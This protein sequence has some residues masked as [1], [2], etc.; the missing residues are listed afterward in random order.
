MAEIKIGR[1]RM[2][3]KGTWNSTTTYVAQDAVYYDGETFVAKQDVPVGT[4]TTNATYWQKVAQKGTNGQDGATGA[5]GATGPQGP[6]G[7]QG[8]QGETGPQ[9]ATGPQGPQGDIGDTGPVG[10]QGPIGNTGPT[11]ATGP[12][13]PAGPTGPKGDTGNTGAT[14]AIGPQGPQGST[15]PTGA[16][17]PSGPA[18]AHN[19]SSY[20]LRFQNPNGTWG[21]Y[22]NLRGA[23]GATGA[24]G[25]QGAT[26]AQGPQG[27]TGATGATGP[28][29]AVG[30]SG[31]APSH[32]WSGYSLRFM[33]P[34]GTWGAYT[35]LRGA[36]GAQGPQGVQGEQGPQGNTG[37]TGA[38]GPQGIQGP[39]GDQGPIGPQGP[40][41][42]QG[43]TGPKGDT[44]NTGAQGSTGPQGATGPTPAH[45]WSGTSLRFYNGTAWGSYVNLK[46]DTGAQGPQGP[47]GVG[48][49]GNVEMTGTLD[50]NNYDIYGV[51]QIFHHG[52]TNTYMQFHAS[53]QWRVV[54]GGAERLEV[55]NTQITSAEPIYAPSFHG[56][57]S[58]L[59][60]ISTDRAE[61][62]FEGGALHSGYA[63]TSFQFGVTGS[64]YD[65]YEILIRNRHNTPAYLYWRPLVGTTAYNLTA[66][67]GASSGGYMSLH[68][69]TSSCSVTRLFVS[70]N[71][72]SA[73]TLSYYVIGFSTGMST[74]T[75][76]GGIG[77]GTASNIRM[78]GIQILSSSTARPL[79]KVYGV[80]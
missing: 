74:S 54:T 79:L 17:G 4:A 20:S 68:S 22:T 30:P 11:G 47:Q 65:W 35:N 38:T 69:N 19:W 50:M 6:Q 9:G 21:A 33:N 51:D 59:T 15:G 13:G 5:T 48:F 41:G 78:D 7:I 28:Q 12:Q 52:D 34:N 60:G 55:N 57:G 10:P 42:P 40:A 18:P 37:A 36:T 64:N 43:A 27:N 24:T 67:Q 44:G 71:P 58:G 80:K 32:A 62:I 14:G 31:P 23:T 49:S 45:Q 63:A 2:G 53:D 25:P 3:W 76:V 46:G 8:I 16:V 70:N 39:V 1:V 66:F 75:H 61:L 26:G 29:G 73:N 77:G 72:D 56:S